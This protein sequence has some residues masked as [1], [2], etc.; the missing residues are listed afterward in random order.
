MGLAA[1]K[2][3]FRTPQG[4]TAL[5]KHDNE[6]HAV[7]AED[8]AFT[9]ILMSNPAVFSKDL[10]RQ[11]SGMFGN[12]RKSEQEVYRGVIKRQREL[13]Q[14]IP[15]EDAY[16]PGIIST[17]VNYRILRA[18]PLP[19]ASRARLALSGLA[20]IVSLPSLEEQAVS[21]TTTHFHI[22]PTEP[23]VEDIWVKLELIAAFYPAVVIAF[24][25]VTVKDYA[26][27]QLQHSARSNFLEEKGVQLDACT[28]AAA[29]RL[30]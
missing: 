24:D 28:E 16:Q 25:N 1:Y 11:R 30:R 26:L 29:I 10:R 20:I 15:R 13:F 17:D 12:A 14:G 19:K 23:D 8:R 5:A 4:I 22:H 21:V 3:Y 7:I 6:R 18:H 9:L 2:V 27:V